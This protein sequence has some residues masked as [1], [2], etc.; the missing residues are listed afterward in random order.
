MMIDCR[1]VQCV[2]NVQKQ[3]LSLVQVLL[4]PAMKPQEAPAQVPGAEALTTSQH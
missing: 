4:F 2:C 3:S 1:R